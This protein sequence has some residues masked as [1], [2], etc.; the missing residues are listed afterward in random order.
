MTQ[1]TLAGL[2]AISKI[3]LGPAA[4]GAA[5]WLVWRREKR[6]DK[7][8]EEQL[9]QFA[10]IT[11]GVRSSCQTLALIHESVSDSN[12][13]MTAHEQKGQDIHVDIR[14]IQDEMVALKGIVATRTDSGAILDRLTHLSNAIAN[15]SGRIGGKEVVQ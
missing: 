12:T 11:E 7:L 3:G 9:K 5:C 14:K 10:A 1:E 15:L 13:T 4:F 6:Q 2:E 8:S